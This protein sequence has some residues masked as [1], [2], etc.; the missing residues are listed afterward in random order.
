[1]GSGGRRRD[2]KP[3]SYHRGN[4]L[5]GTVGIVAFPAISTA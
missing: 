1:M 5:R 2:Q 3:T 4:A